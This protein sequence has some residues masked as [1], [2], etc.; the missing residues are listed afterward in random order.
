MR[1]LAR[2]YSVRITPTTTPLAAPCSVAIPTRALRL[3]VEV[4]V[5]RTLARRSSL[6][7]ALYN[8]MLFVALHRVSA[9]SCTLFHDGRDKLRMG[10]AHLI[11]FSTHVSTDTNFSI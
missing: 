11:L 2:A 8:P 3:E 5:C 1:I 10:R 9:V 4:E 7:L 6:L